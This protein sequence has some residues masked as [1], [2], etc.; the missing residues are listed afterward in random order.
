[1]T[2]KKKWYAVAKGRKPG[3]Y[4]Q[5]YGDRGAEIQVRGFAGAVFKGFPSYQEAREWLK[6]PDSRKAVVGWSKKASRQPENTAPRPGDVILY[7]D[8]G[9]MHN[10]G[11]GGFGAVILTKD[12]RTEL[13]GGFRLTTN[14]RMELTACIAGLAS[15]KEKSS[16]SLYSDSRYVVHG[17]EKGWAR[18]WRA[19]GWKKPDG[20]KALNPDLWER[21]LDLCEYHD[22][23]FIWVKG[24]AGNPENERCD[25][26]AAAAATGDGLRV[27][28][29]YQP[30]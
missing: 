23:R 27:D 4:E 25:Q 8:G 6:N 15:L 22:V 12:A 30:G 2:V 21:L 13:S 18:N 16:V 29:G 26:L 7:T 3:I 17:I 28:A 9:C 1:M 19:R 14:N 10:P 20:Q 5:W 24:H 11:P